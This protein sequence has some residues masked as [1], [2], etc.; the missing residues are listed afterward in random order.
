MICTDTDNYVNLNYKERNQKPC[1]FK[2]AYL[3][4][5]TSY[6]N[7]FLKSTV[8]NAQKHLQRFYSFIVN[9]LIGQF[10]NSSCSF[11][12]IW[13]FFHEN[14]RFTGQQ[15]KRGGFLFNYSLPLL[16]ALQ[17]T[18]GSSPLHVASSR[19]RTGNLW[20]PRTSH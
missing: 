2:V 5:R 3:F 8:L 16:P 14:S 10:L 13:V 15:G 17:T 6:S 18:A 11:F 7:I 12:S 9:V 4:H 1:S 20:L 19:V